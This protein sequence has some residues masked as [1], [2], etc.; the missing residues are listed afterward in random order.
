MNLINNLKKKKAIS[1][2]KK[3]DINDLAEKGKYI[4]SLCVNVE[5]DND[6]APIEHHL[7][8]R[9][10]LLSATEPD[11]WLLSDEEKEKIETYQKELITYANLV[12]NSYYDY[13]TANIIEILPL[14]LVFP[15]YSATTIGW[16]MGAGEIYEEI[17]ATFLNNLN[18]KEFALYKAKYPAPEY[19]SLRSRY[20]FS[21]EY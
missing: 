10:P 20:N 12:I 3:Q 18:K 15:T 1:R 8:L 2:L 14:W 6:I 11:N 4:L 9:N 5:T 13:R 17:Y 21:E 16:R 7:P 19:M